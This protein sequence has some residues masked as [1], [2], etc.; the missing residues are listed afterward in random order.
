MPQTR[1]QVTVSPT[2]TISRAGSVIS[3]NGSSN[4]VVVSVGDPIALSGAVAGLPGGV[5]ISSQSWAPGGTVVS[6]YVQS[7][8]QGTVTSFSAPNAGSLTFYWIDS[9]N[10]TNYPVTYTAN[11]SNNTTLT[12]TALFHVA[13]PTPFSLSGTVS[14]MTP[15]VN[16]SNQQNVDA[17]TP[18]LNFGY[19][20]SFNDGSPGITYNMQ[21]TTGYGGS[22][23]L[24]QP[25]ST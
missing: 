18:T 19:N 12:A 8:T 13:R 7:L 6:N 9:D 20:P 22:F 23:A 25:K 2:V 11:L 5:T 16:T 15:V 4:P 10:M 24:L 3:G 14:S 21:A 17:S 1:G